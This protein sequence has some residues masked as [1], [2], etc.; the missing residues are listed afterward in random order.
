MVIPLFVDKDANTVLDVPVDIE[1][2][3]VLDFLIINGPDNVNIPDVVSS[4]VNP[5]L[6]NEDVVTTGTPVSLLYSTVPV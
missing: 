1:N 6:F 3:L 2:T 4:A 5:L